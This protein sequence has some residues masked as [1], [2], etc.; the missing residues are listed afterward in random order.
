MARRV[1]APGPKD[2]RPDTYGPACTVPPRPAAGEAGRPARC[3][4]ARR[5]AAWPS[6][7]Q[8]SL[9]KSRRPA[10]RRGAAG[11]MGSLGKSRRRARL[12]WASRLQGPDSNLRRRRRESP[13]R[14]RPS[15]ADEVRARPGLTLASPDLPPSSTQAL[16]KKSKLC[17]QTRAPLR[18]D[19]ARVARRHADA[20]S[21]GCEQLHNACSTRTYPLKKSARLTK[22]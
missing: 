20:A 7:W 3:G 2:P 10:G 5:G 17:K 6:E 19:A 22:L 13:P 14:A 18:R 15:R 21:H 9:E 11:W 1:P 4:A 12:S 8:G 16:A